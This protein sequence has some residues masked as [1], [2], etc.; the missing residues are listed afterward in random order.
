MQYQ[1][2]S[3]VNKQREQW[4]R[5]ARA[6]AEQFFGD[7]VRALD[8]RIAEKRAEQRVIMDEAAFERRTLD[9]IE[10]A[11]FN[12]LQSYIHEARNKLYS[13]YRRALPPDGLMV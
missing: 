1:S 12:L 8:E 5:E 6:K 2:Y 10:A 3:L 4:R 9:R 7:E 13:L 11:N